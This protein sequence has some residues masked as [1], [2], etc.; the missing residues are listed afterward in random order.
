MGIYIT[1]KT[2]KLSKTLKNKITYLTGLNIRRVYST[3]G[4]IQLN[5]SLLENIQSTLGILFY[6]SK[7]YGLEVGCD[8]NKLDLYI[9]DFTYNIQYILIYQLIGTVFQKTV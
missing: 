1:L 3:L 4:C 8:R 7:F 6:F 2:F 5:S 9:S